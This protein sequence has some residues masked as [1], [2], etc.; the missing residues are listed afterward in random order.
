MGTMAVGIQYT[1][2]ELRKLYRHYRHQTPS[3]LY[4]LLK[5]D[6]GINLPK[7]TLEVLNRYKIVT[8]HVLSLTESRY[9]FKLNQSM[10]LNWY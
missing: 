1:V 6:N 4:R 10:N 2:D 7:D 8:N 9:D 5:R 3:K